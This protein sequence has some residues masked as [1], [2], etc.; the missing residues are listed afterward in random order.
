MIKNIIIDFDRT[1]VALYDDKPYLLKELNQRIIKHYSRYIDVDKEFYDKDGYH[2]WYLL[3]ELIKMKYS[4]NYGYRI[5]K[6]AEDI[7]K[8]IE[9]TALKTSLLFIGVEE[10]LNRLLKDGYSLMIA[11]NNSKEVIEEYL[12]KHNLKKYFLDISGRGKTLNTCR[13]KPSPY[14]INRLIRIHHLSKDETLYVGDDIND[15]KTALAAGVKSV[16]VASGRH[17]IKDLKEAGS[18][19]VYKDFVEFAST[20]TSII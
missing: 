13:I 20:L 10:A 18:T 5:N 2:S 11:S 1:L 15:I 9:L 3:N 17:N 16:G 7:V 14:M 6:C 4:K 8:D 12:L 19:Y